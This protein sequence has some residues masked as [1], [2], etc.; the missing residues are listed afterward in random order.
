MALDLE[1]RPISKNEVADYERA[2]AR[3]FGGHASEED[4]ARAEA[5]LDVERT[6]A[7]FHDGEI[8]GTARS[9]VSDIAVPGGSLP[10]AAV[11][12]VAVIPTNRRRGVLTR[13]TAH[14]LRDVR[15]RGEPLAALWASESIIYGRFGYGVSTTHET[16]KIDRRHTAFTIPPETAGQVSFVTPEQAQ[17]VFPKVYD[18]LWRGR[19]GMF[20]RGERRWERRFEDSEDPRS[21]ASKFF[22]A[23][24]RIKGRTEGYAI[25]RI[26][27]SDSTLVVHELLAA[28]DEAYAALWQYCFGVDLISTIEVAGPYRE[29]GRP[30]DDPL[31]WM[32]ADQRRLER[33]PID[34][35]Y[36]RLVDVRSALAGRTFAADGKLVLQLNDRFCDWNDGRWAVEGG[37]QGA[38]CRRSRARPD[39]TLTA[40]DLAAAY[41]GGVSFRTLAHA[42]RVEA[43]GPAA[44]SKADAMFAT[45]R[46]PWCGDFF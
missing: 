3:G 29:T 39:L 6:V 33:T 38:Q 43:A 44:L 42:G 26:R 22:F 5:K 41:L 27:H 14:Q 17:E 45:D 7:A 23:G 20:K 12:G 8:V 10:V 36:L 16:W 4:V 32:L 15:D 46:Q 37:P 11:A 2:S 28:T 9:F 25:Y 35:L 34:A 24:Y 30:T 31:P 40:A 19:P 1:V 18:R 21:G 13:M